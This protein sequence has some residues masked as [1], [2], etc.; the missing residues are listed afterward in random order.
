MPNST[1]KVRRKGRVTK[2][3]S[4]HGKYKE[5]IKKDGTIKQVS[6]VD[7]KRTVDKFKRL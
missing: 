1:I 4:D 3:K 2:V 7:G 6:W 5:K